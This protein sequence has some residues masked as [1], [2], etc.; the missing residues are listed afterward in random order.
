VNPFGGSQDLRH[1]LHGQSN[2]AEFSWP[3]MQFSGGSA[4]PVQIPP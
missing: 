1:P 3:G 2:V 4:A